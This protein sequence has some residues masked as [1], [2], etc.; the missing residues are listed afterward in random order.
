MHLRKTKEG[1]TWVFLTF[2]PSLLML[3]LNLISVQ[4]F[5]KVYSFWETESEGSFLKKSTCALFS[6]T[7]N[8]L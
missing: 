3:L 4:Y 6:V 5:S 7:E 8:L 2:G 1:S